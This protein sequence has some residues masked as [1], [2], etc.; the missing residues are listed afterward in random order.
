[1]PLGHFGAGEMLLSCGVLWVTQSVRR[2][3]RSGEV[4]SPPQPTGRLTDISGVLYASNGN[5]A[6]ALCTL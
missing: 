4:L 1:M 5:Y 2:C 6:V 3:E